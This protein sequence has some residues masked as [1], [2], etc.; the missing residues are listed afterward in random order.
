[1]TKTALLTLGRL[2]K[3][4]DIARALHMDGWRV[5]IA[6]PS[7]WHLSRVSNCVS[8][9]VSVTAPNDNQSQYIADLLTVIERENVELVVPISEEALHATLIEG[10]LPEN[11]RLFSTKKM[12]AAANSAVNMGWGYQSISK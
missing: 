11:V 4:L 6:E 10:H 1:M 5:I 7:K 8:K 2:P 9:C 3:S 12:P